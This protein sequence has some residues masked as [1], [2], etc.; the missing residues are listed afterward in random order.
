LTAA[1]CCRAW[2][3]SGRGWR[4]APCD[5]PPRHGEHFVC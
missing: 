4:C 2:A 3:W 5:R 1:C